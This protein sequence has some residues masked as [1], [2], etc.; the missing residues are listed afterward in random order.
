MWKQRFAK[1]KYG[2]TEYEAST[3]PDGSIRY[4]VRGRHGVWREISPRDLPR[5]ARRELDAQLSRENPLSNRPSDTELLVGGAASIVLIG[6]GIY[7][8]YTAVNP[9]TPDATSTLEDTSALAT[10]ATLAV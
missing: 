7:L 2:P 1:T 10:L 8:V 4:S 3:N 9:A 5:G 6:F